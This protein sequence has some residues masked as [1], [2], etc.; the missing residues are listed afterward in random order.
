MD[1]NELALQLSAKHIDPT[2][3]DIFGANDFPTETYVIRP[4][5]AGIIG[6]PDYWV[7]YYSERGLETGLRRFESEDAACRYFVDWVASDDTARII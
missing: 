7:T 1:R 4:R 3:Y 2:A 5:R 6:E